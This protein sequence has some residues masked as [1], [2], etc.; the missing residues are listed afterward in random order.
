MAKKKIAQTR[1]LQLTFILGRKSF[2]FGNRAGFGLLSWCHATP[3]TARN[4]TNVIDATKKVVFV[5]NSDGFDCAHS[6]GRW[7]CADRRRFAQTIGVKSRNPI[8]QG[9]T[10]FQPTKFKRVTSFHPK[11]RLAA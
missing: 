6:P 1:F 11:F 2:V 10:D 4:A 7:C 8:K 5:Q 3:L 9:K